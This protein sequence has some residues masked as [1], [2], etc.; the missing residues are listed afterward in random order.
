MLVGLNHGSDGDGQ[1]RGWPM[2][3]FSE[4]K[5]FSLDKTRT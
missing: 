4:K 5:I 1:R 2:T 3:G